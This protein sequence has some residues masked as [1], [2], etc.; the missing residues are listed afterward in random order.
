MAEQ[1]TLN[2]LVGS[3]SLPRLTSKPEHETAL[4]ERSVEGRSTVCTT[5]RT[6]LSWENL[7]AE[8]AI[9]PV[10]GPLERGRREVDIDVG[11]RRDAGV[12]EDPALER[13]L[14]PLGQELAA[15]LG[16]PVPRHAGGK[17]ST[18]RTA[19]RPW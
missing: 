19:C 2:Q 5:A 13:D 3:S 17:C 8:D 4:P 6:T 10:R 12:P 16:E 15:G 18:R 7:P 11:R 9:H 14:L 1:L